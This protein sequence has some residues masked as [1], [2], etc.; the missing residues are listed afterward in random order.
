MKEEERRDRL[1]AN[2][3]VHIQDVI[4]K[5]AQVDTNMEKLI[6]KNENHKVEIQH[7]GKE[8]EVQEVQS[9]GLEERLKALEDLMEDQVMKIIGLEE[10][11]AVLRSRKACRVGR[12]L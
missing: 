1:E 8:Q 11:I 12:R 2:T 7:L 6:K 5:M 9:S 10:K 4:K 3:N